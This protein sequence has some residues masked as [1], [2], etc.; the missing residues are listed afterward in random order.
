MKNEIWKDII[1]YKGHY[2]VS[3][4]G[5]IKSFK[6]KKEGAILKLQ[7][8]HEGYMHIGLSLNGAKKTLMVHRLVGFAFI[9]NPNNKPCI[10]HKDGI[11]DNNNLSNLE[12]VTKSENTRHAHSIGLFYK[13]KKHWHW[14]GHS[15]IQK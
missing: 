5:R 4:L 10:N 2:M 6:R 8:T 1:G 14:D 15:L 12:W 3:N 11:K 9:K 7:K 13:N